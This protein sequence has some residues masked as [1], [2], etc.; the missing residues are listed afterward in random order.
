M[1]GGVETGVVFGEQVVGG[2]A[3]VIEEPGDDLVKT[4]ASDRQAPEPEQDLA[5]APRPS[6]KVKGAPLAP[7]LTTIFSVS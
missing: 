3:V 2:G 7:L 6:V 1:L 4:D 5:G